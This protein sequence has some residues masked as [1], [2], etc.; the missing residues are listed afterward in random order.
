MGMTVN[1]KHK[2]HIILLYFILFYYFSFKNKQIY[3]PIFPFTFKPKNS[4]PQLN[5]TQLNSIKTF[6]FIYLFIYFNKCI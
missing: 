3:I 4:K 6:L 1:S 5:S 2:L